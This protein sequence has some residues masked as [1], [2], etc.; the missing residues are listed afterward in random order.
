MKLQMMAEEFDV[1]IIEFTEDDIVRD[2]FVKKYI[3]TK[4]R[5]GIAA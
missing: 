4:N 1:G 5:L 3:K 2:E